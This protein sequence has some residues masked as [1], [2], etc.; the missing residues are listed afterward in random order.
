MINFN[1]VNFFLHIYFY[2]RDFFFLRALRF[3][4][5]NTPAANSYRKSKLFVETIIITII[6]TLIII[7]TK[8]LILNLLLFLTFCLNFVI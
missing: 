2:V 8:M 1:F 4:F 7:F 5:Q 6:I 3:K